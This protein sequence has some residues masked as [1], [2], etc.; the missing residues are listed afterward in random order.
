ME[1]TFSRCFFFIRRGFG[2]VSIFSLFSILG[3]PR[4]LAL[5]ET[6]TGR[7]F[8]LLSAEVW[9]QRF[10]TLLLYLFWRGFGRVSFFSHFSVLGQP[11]GLARRKNHLYLMI[12]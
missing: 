10:T 7:F 12:D 5:I 8:I 9:K 4:G 1:A 2:R 6:S 3:Q 11:L